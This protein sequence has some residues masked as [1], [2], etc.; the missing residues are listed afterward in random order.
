MEKAYFELSYLMSQLV[1]RLT[2][3]LIAKCILS[4]NLKLI[5]MRAKLATLDYCAV[6][7]LSRAAV[8]LSWY[9]YSNYIAW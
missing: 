2:V 8:N 4:Y 1:C 3:G 5:K 9:D 7:F 6:T